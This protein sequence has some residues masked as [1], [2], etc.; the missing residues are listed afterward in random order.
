MRRS[1]VRQGSSSVGPSQA[2][3]A[4]QRPRSQSGSRVRFGDYPTPVMTAARPYTASAT[5]RTGSVSPS[6]SRVGSNHNQPMAT[7][8]P[9]SARQSSTG[10][11]EPDLDSR[12]QAEQMYLDMLDAQVSRQRQEQAKKLQMHETL[13]E[14]REPSSQD[15]LRSILEK[16]NHRQNSLE[17]LNQLLLG[18]DTPPAKQ[19]E[20]VESAAGAALRKY[21]LVGSPSPVPAARAERSVVCCC[22]HTADDRCCL[23]CLK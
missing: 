14:T 2:P 6:V 12:L 20:P 16:S 11:P 23:K 13:P 22:Y 8:A 18:S 4:G 9:Q 21:G 19:E 7:E 15:E 1:N 10:A 17:K 5:N 3:A